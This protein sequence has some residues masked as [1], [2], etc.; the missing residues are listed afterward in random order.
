[1][2]FKLKRKAASDAS[3][4]AALIFIIGALIVL[5]I[6]LL[7]PEE[8]AKVLDLE[9]E[10]IVGAD[11]E[12]TS[13]LLSES[14]KRLFPVDDKEFE[15]LFSAVNIYVAEEGTELKRVDS[16][17][18]KKSLF[19]SKK[20]NIS[21][22]I[23]KL[24]DVKNALLNFMVEEGKGRLII[25]LNGNEIFDKKV[26]QGNINPIELDENLIE[27]KNVIEFE[28]SSP[29]GTFWRTNRYS[30][31]DVMIT[32]D[33]LM[34]DTQEGT[35]TFIVD[36]TEID[37]LKRIRLRY[38]PECNEKTA[39]RL[40]IS[41]NNYEVHSAVPADCN[42]YSRPIE[43]LPDRLVVGENKLKFSTT[44]GWYLIDNI[45]LTSE[46]KEI[47]VPVYYFE[48]EEDDFEDVQDK[49]A[50]VTLY[51][52]FVD[53]VTRKIADITVNNHLIRLDQEKIEFNETIS[54]LVEEGNNAIKI[55]P[56]DILDIVELKVKLES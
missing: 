48:L 47:I 25:M 42:I 34:R 49:K 52:K 13:I 31:E 19:T 51:M 10:T 38:L 24:E 37:N 55:E 1:M 53:D 8:R 54:K 15:R 21:F 2:L 32:A 39:G 26:E 23:P 56:E 6:L 28:A 3:A 27:G 14:P 41:I 9:N 5:F 36:P 12:D 50:N 40:S 33:F 30:L 44:K 22:D 4:A 43:F 20:V 45:K 16:L 46:L 29:G 11:E 18:V 7:S 17:Y 35:L